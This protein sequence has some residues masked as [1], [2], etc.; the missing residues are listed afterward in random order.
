MNLRVKKVL[1]SDQP[2]RQKLSYMWMYFG[3][4][5]LVFVGLLVVLVFFLGQV[6]T[7]KDSI[8]TVGIYTQGMSNPVATKSMKREFQ[9]VLVPN[10]KQ[11]VV[12]TWN[13]LA[14][15]DIMAKFLGTVNDHSVDI[16]IT[17][18]KLFKQVEKDI[19]CEVLPVNTGIRSA[20]GKKMKQYMNRNNHIIGIKSD[21]VE[22][23]KNYQIKDQ[24]IYV[25]K[26]SKNISS[27]MKLIRSL[28]E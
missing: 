26:K 9:K 15:R 14:K 28:T 22:F 6:V 7:R 20:S 25:P 27:A 18:E 8:L 5:F 11:E 10:K 19:G 1:K 23:F 16:L 17:N 13:D 3:K 12:V 21:D 2:F 24:V 4:L